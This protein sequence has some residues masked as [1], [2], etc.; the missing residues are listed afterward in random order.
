[1]SDTP[2]KNKLNQFDKHRLC[3]Y[4]EGYTF[5]NRND[6]YTVVQ[7]KG[8]KMEVK[9][10]KHGNVIKNV[11]VSNIKRGE[12]VVNPL[13]KSVYGVGYLGEGNPKNVTKLESYWLWKNMLQRCYFKREDSNNSKYLSEVTVCNEWHCFYNFNKWFDENHPSKIE[14]V[15]FELDKDLHYIGNSLKSGKV[16]SPETCV[17]LPRDINGALSSVLKRLDKRDVA[18]YKKGNQFR[19][20]VEK[21]IYFKDKEEAVKV[22]ISEAYLK[23]KTLLFHY[24]DV[25]TSGVRGSLELILENLIVLH[26]KGESN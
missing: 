20:N 15:K 12:R 16:Y 8:G 14:N 13:E 4:K 3:E 9:S 18:V 5:S 25:I 26:R 24:K 17:F 19:I 6:T 10:H 11:Y 21:D 23:I 7:R 2:V 1:M 22:K